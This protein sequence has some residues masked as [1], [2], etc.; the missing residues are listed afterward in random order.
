MWKAWG[1]VTW[2][3]A[4]IPK[5]IQ[6]SNLNRDPNIKLAVCPI[7]PTTPTTPLP[8]TELLWGQSDLPELASPQEVNGF[9]TAKRIEEHLA[10]RFLLSQ[11]LIEW[12]VEDLSSLEVVRDDKRAPSLAW[13][14]GTFKTQPLP[15]ISIGHSGEWAI[16][17]L[18]SPEWFVGVD[19]EP[20][21][22]IISPSAFPMMA[23]GDELKGLIANPA[24]AIILWTVKE[25]VQ[26]CMRMGMH[27]NPRDVV[28]DYGTPIEIFE[29]KFSIEKSFIQLSSWVNSGQRISLAF[30]ESTHL[31]KSSL[32]IL[33]DQTATE[34]KNFTHVNEQGV[35]EYSFA[36]G[37]STTRNSR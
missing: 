18:V 29:A 4:K 8:N 22:R 5:G 35:K 17:A 6:S 27:L 23:K 31:P 11:M 7:R 9:A 15:N 37:C 25:A 21:G 34:M 28:L 32:D 20:V 10:G 12:G 13:I 14:E 33:L 24:S 26:K 3:E 36:V 19:A 1:K 2:V 16:V 30:R